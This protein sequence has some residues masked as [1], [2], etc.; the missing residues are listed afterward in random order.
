MVVSYGEAIWDAQT[1]R[2][3]IGSPALSAA[4]GEGEWE[5]QNSP[6]VRAYGN[7][8]ASGG[9]RV[10]RPDQRDFAVSCVS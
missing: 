1:R 3:S 7:P 10:D 9:W 2:R 4:Y 8:A 5:E 6:K